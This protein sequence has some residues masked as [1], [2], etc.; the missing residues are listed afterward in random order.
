MAEL[1]QDPRQERP[2]AWSVSRAA[3]VLSVV[4]TTI[5]IAGAL[6]ILLLARQPERQPPPGQAS[7]SAAPTLAPSP[8]AV[9]GRMPMSGCGVVNPGTALRVG[10][11]TQIRDLTARCELTAWDGR[12][13]GTVTLVYNGDRPDSDGPRF[14]TWGTI[15]IDAQD[16]RWTGTWAGITEPFGF[17]IHHEMAGVADREPGGLRLRWTLDNAWRKPL[18]AGGPGPVSVG[19]GWNVFDTYFQFS[20]VFE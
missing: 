2:F 7:A 19:G 5:V 13:E 6:A 20:G 18:S 1:G 9:T 11:L 16:G 4:A 8:T 3:A 15:R 14:A 17:A 12:F 10:T